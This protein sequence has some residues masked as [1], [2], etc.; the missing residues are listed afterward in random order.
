MDRDEGRIQAYALC[1]ELHGQ[2]KKQ[3]DEFQ[4]FMVGIRAAIGLAIRRKSF[5]HPAILDGHSFQFSSGFA[6]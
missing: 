3:T 1:Q 6:T 2:L 4:S 5:A